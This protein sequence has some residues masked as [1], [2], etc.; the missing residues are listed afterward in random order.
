[1]NTKHHETIERLNKLSSQSEN[2][3][4][5]TA[6]IRSDWSPVEHNR[7]RRIAERKLKSLGEALGLMDI[8]AV[9]GAV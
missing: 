2:V 1:M 6:S 9:T 8:S 7:R 5:R 4:R 3:V